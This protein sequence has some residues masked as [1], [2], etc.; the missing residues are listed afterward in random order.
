MASGWRKRRARAN[1]RAIT[2][3]NPCRL[4]IPVSA[5]VSARLAISRA[6]P[7]ASLCFWASLDSVPELPLQDHEGGDDH[8]AE[9]ERDED[10]EQPVRAPERLLLEGDD[11]P[12]GAGRDMRTA[13]WRAPSMRT[14]LGPDGLAGEERARPGVAGPSAGRAVATWAVPRRPSDPATSTCP[15]A[16]TR[17]EIPVPAGRTTRGEDVLHDRDAD[18]LPA[19]SRTGSLA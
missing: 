7:S 2:S 19:G 6:R 17:K 13:T 8:Q 11:G 15:S 5:S 3:L 14:Q 10:A 9:E 1:S 12:F 4:A 16:P 18:H